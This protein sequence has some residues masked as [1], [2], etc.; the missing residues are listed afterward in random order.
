[1][2]TFVGMDLAWARRART[3]LAALAAD[4]RLVASC[5]VVSDDEIAAFV[6]QHAP[7]EVVAAIDA[8]IVVPNGTGRRDCEARL[9][10]I[11][12]RYDAGAH[13]TNR[14]RPYFDPP[15]ARTLAERFG[16]DVDPSVAPACGTSV[17]IEVY[18]HPAMVAL[19]GLSR[20][21]PY[22]HKPG[23]GLVVLRHASSE[24]LDLMERVASPLRLPSSA[25]WTEIRRSVHEASRK[26]ALRTV[27]DEIDAVF[28]AYLAWLWVHERARM[29]VLGDV[30]RGY[31]VIPGR[32]TV[33]PRTDRPAR[34]SPDRTGRSSRS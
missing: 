10:E 27:E 32:P 12:G 34:A 33:E 30:D 18:P 31:I 28:C 21:I 24:V 26:S 5:S 9:G 14:S 20:V 15:R 1:M 25:R 8:P 22:K 4:G 16:W 13:P 7:G 6:A 17:A 23:R 19:F 2:V 3:G 29:E 11:F